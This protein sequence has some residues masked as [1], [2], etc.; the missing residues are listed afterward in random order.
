MAKTT[1]RDPP[2]AYGWMLAH[3]PPSSEWGPGGNTGEIKAA[4]KGTDHPTSKSRWPRTS[5]LSNR[6]SPTYGS[7]TGLT[8][9]FKVTKALLKL[10]CICFIYSLIRYM[11]YLLLNFL[12]KMPLPVVASTLQSVDIAAV[13]VV[14]EIVILNS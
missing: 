4:R 9:T 5:V 1:L 2:R 10:K 8:F 6:S 11:Y 3:C 12:L 14:D 7:Y 13:V